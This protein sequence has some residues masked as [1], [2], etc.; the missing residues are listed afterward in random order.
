MEKIKLSHADSTCSVDNQFL[1][2]NFWHVEWCPWAYGD[3]TGWRLLMEKLLESLIESTP[4]SEWPVCRPLACS[5]FHI[6][7]PS[8]PDHKP[9]W[10]CL[11]YRSMD[12]QSHPE[13]RPTVNNCSELTTDQ[14]I[15]GRCPLLTWQESTPPC[16]WPAQNIVWSRTLP[17]TPFWE[18]FAWLMSSTLASS[19]WLEPYLAAKTQG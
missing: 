10:S 8:S 3:V 11:P 19:R 2:Y 6:G 5:S 16:R 17:Y 12:L 9:H 4:E 1:G 14:H 18:H 7:L 15:T 13:T